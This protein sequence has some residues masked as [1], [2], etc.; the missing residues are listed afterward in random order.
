MPGVE[1]LVRHLYLHKIPICIATGS[2][3]Y[4][5]DL[6]TRNHRGLF[7]LFHHVVTPEN[8][9]VKHGKPAPDLFQVLVFIFMKKTIISLFDI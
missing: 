2:S 6:K 7:S 3:L 8:P 1:K 9:L 4:H 5:Y